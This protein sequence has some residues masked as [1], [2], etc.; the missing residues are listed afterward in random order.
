MTAGCVGELGI[1]FEAIIG[2]SL[3][4]R[5]LKGFSGNPTLPGSH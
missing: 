3:G 1:G 2:A 4:D 5:A